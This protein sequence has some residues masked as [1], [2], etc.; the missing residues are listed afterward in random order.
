MLQS[1]GIGV[2]LVGASLVSGQWSWCGEG[3]M[4]WGAIAMVLETNRGAWRMDKV[5]SMWCVHIFSWWCGVCK[6]FRFGC[7]H[8]LWHS[9]DV[10][11]AF[12]TCQIV[13]VSVSNTWLGFWN[14][15]LETRMGYLKVIQCAQS[16]DT[17]FIQL[18]ISLATVS[19]PCSS[20]RGKTNCPSTEI[21]QR[22]PNS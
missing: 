19:S 15:S 14:Q 13:F 12:R 11:M 1:E 2:L 6:Y 17:V 7:V 10:T 22:F 21:W 3:Q 5:I 4:R 8:Y 9:L 18:V 16:S 20:H